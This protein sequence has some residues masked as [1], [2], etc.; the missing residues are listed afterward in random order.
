MEIKANP[1]DIIQP[2][3]NVEK[4]TS[5]FKWGGVTKD[6]ISR[7][8]G[9]DTSVITPKG[10]KIEMTMDDVKLYVERDIQFNRTYY[11]D[12]FRYS[13]TIEAGRK[14]AKTMEQ[15]LEMGNHKGLIK[16]MLGQAVKKWNTADRLDATVAKLSPEERA[17]RE[18]VYKDNLESEAEITRREKE[19]GKKLE[20]GLPPELLEVGGG[21]NRLESQVFL[22]YAVVLAKNL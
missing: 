5:F 18:I 17:Q 10:K 11:P 7:L 14:R 1:N 6:L 19:T 13:A 12:G 15:M 16:L 8:S 2:Q 20:H 4:I 21:S 3:S 22:A 9:M